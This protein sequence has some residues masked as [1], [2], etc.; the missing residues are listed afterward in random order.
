[1]AKLLGITFEKSRWLYYVAMLLAFLSSAFFLL[2]LVGEGIADLFNGSLEVIPILLMMLFTVSGFF[3]AFKRHKRGGMIMTA[4]GFLMLIYLLIMGGG[5]AWYAALIFGLPFII[6]GLMLL[7]FWKL[8]TE[9][10]Q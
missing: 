3:I 8:Q 6:P 9:E 1:M 2:F 7:L 4:G 10:K 5:N